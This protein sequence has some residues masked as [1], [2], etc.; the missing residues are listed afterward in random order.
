MAEVF[1]VSL[2]VQTLTTDPFH[3]VSEVIKIL[4]YVNLPSNY[5]FFFWFEENHRITP[6]TQNGAAGSVRLQLTKNPA[7]SLNCPGCRVRGITF[8]LFPRPRQT[9]GPLSA[10]YG[11]TIGVRYRKQHLNCCH[12]CYGIGSRTQ[13]IFIWPLGSCS[14]SGC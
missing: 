14:W 2:S 5:F 13:Q 8:E 7:R 4:L 11:C 9:F 6:A 3:C 12:A 1:A 10:K